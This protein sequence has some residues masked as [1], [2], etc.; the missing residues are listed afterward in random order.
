M[1][2]IEGSGFAP[3]EIR[4][5]IVTNGIELMQL[6]GKEFGVGDAVFRGVKYCEPCKIPAKLIGSNLNFMNAFHDRGGIIAEVVQG[7]MIRV[8]DSVVPHKKK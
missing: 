7:G 3:I 6:I 1:R 2:A 8:G 5:N 4:R